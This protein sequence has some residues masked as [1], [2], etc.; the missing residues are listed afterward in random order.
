MC[1]QK[2]KMINENESYIYISKVGYARVDEFVQSTDQ[3]FDVIIH[4]VIF[5]TILLVHFVLPFAS[6]R[7][8]SK[9]ADFK[10]MWTKYQQKHARVCGERI[11]FDKHKILTWSLCVLSWSL[12]IIL[13]LAEYFLQPDFKFWHTFAYYHIMATLNCFC[14]LW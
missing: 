2:Q 12:G 9:V 14:S 4:R 6:W 1:C 11:L 5:L 8:G 13:V 10:N 3:R 7:N